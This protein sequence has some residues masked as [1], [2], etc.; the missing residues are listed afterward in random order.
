MM[1]LK[2][3]SIEPAGGWHYQHP[4]TK[5]DLR[6][7]C[8][9]NLKKLYIR[10]SEANG[11]TYPANYADIIEDWICHNTAKEFVIVPEGQVFLGYPTI[12]KI[13]AVALKMKTLSA[14]VIDPSEAAERAATCMACPM[15]NPTVCLPCAGYDKIFRQMFKFTEEP[16]DRRLM[17]CSCDHTPLMV[18]VRLDEL[19]VRLYRTENEHEPFPANCWKTRGDLP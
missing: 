13:Y 7:N 17:A 12:S 16:F 14:G 6:S 9:D 3:Y 5:L 19:A 10:H 8:F 15:N 11:F 18:W 4:K 2:S 1:K